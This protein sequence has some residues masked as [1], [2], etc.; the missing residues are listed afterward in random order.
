MAR[1]ISLGS[2]YY[3]FKH[4]NSDKISPT[5][6]HLLI[7]AHGGYASKGGVFSKKTKQFK[8]PG[9]CQLYF[10]GDHTF[11]LKD[12]KIYPIMK[13]EYQVKMTI[14][15]GGMVMDY[16]LSKYQGKHG[17]KDETYDSIKS[18]IDQNNKAVTGDD[19]EYR[20]K[21]SRNYQYS[22]DVLTVRNRVGSGDPTLSEL[23]KALDQGGFRYENIH[24]S[25]CR[26]DMS[27][28]DSPSMSATKWGT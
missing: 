22:F 19:F 21:Q 9:W 5:E 6:D 4:D 24:C 15:S 25:F 18:N 28:D 1:Q 23:L 8:V 11:T 10:Y 12:P 16:E 17:N 2:K 14:P 26:S 20:N 27:V 3:I 7:T 13:G